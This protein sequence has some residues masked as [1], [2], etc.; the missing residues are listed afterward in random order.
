VQWCEINGRKYPSSAAASATPSS[1]DI[2]SPSPSR[3]DAGR[4]LPATPT[5]SSPTSSSASAEPHP[6]RVPRRDARIA[7]LEEFGLE[8]I[9]LF[10]TLGVLYEEL[11]ATTGF[12]INQTFT[13]FNRWSRRLGLAY[14]DKIF[15][16]PYISLAR[17]RLGVSE[18]EWAIGVARAPS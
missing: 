2:R 12:A 17:P 10:P 18:L 1:S 8:S 3:R 5:P 7:K 9:W 13:A 11:L 6:G 14:R 16:A 4:L 15:R